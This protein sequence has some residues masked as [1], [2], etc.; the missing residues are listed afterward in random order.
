MKSC[1]AEQHL[2]IRKDNCLELELISDIPATVN[3]THP[4]RASA[5]VAF[6]RFISILRLESTIVI[7]WITIKILIKEKDD[8][9]YFYFLFGHGKGSSPSS[10]ASVSFAW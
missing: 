1:T 2:A 8:C 7:S 5:A 6:V 4:E 3:S 10:K 9:H